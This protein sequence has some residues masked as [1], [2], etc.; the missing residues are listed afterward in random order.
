MINPY[1]NID[2]ANVDYVQSCSHE[3]CESQSQFNKL[4]GSSG[5]RH[6]AISNYYPS[7]P[8]YSL[9]DMF[10]YGIPVDAIECPNAEH[11][12]FSAFG[13][14]YGNLHING[15]GSFYI[16][17]SPRGET[18]V[19][20]DRES[21]FSVIPKILK[22]LQ[23]EDGGG[24]T[25]NHPTWTG[26]TFE[27]TCALLDCDPRVLGIEFFNAT[28]QDDGERGWAID[29]WDEILFSGRKCFG[30]AVADHEGQ[31]T[32]NWRGRNILLVDEAT[33]HSCLQA[34]RNGA[35][36]GQINN[37]PL[38]F[39]SI[40][41]TDR[42]YSVQAS[43]ADTINIIIDGESTEYSST[44]VSVSVPENAVYVRAEAH[45]SNDSIYSNPIT[46]NEYVPPQ[47]NSRNSAHKILVFMS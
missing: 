31:G 16:S 12:N 36:Y 8:V 20:C 15:I 10:S 38:K 21:I 24:V 34:Y 29:L 45:T 14:P 41:L 42:T 7:A 1:S 25:I 19:G 18:P 5:I 37:T 9:S 4:V 13:A 3:H 35:F 17:G 47:R 26:L 44:S 27:Q 32:E 33:E 23:Y 46:F 40:T 11:H 43:Y 22:S 28:S 6:I 30:F 39:D 2:W